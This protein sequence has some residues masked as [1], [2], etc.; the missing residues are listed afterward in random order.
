MP[1]DSVGSLQLAKAREG[2]AKDEFSEWKVVLARTTDGCPRCAAAWRASTGVRLGARG[3][4]R[5]GRQGAALF[6]R[7]GPLRRTSG[8]T[9][10]SVG[11]RESSGLGCLRELNSQ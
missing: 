9:S 6:R 3:W 4:L 5:A 10:L 7:T 11:A 2:P 1:S 8:S